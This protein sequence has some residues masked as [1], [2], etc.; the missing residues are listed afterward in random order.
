[1]SR[2]HA[3]RRARSQW[4]GLDV[5]AMAGAWA[6]VAGLMFALTYAAVGEVVVAGLLTLLALLPVAGLAAKPSASGQMHR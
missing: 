3:R 2:E 4:R 1:M 6:L 5:A